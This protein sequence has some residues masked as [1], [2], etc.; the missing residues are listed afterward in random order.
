MTKSKGINKPRESQE[1][2]ALRDRII[3]RLRD[4]LLTASEV[5]SVWGIHRQ[6]VSRVMKRVYESLTIEQRFERS[7]MPEP[8]SGCWLWT[9]E[10]SGSWGYGR[11]HLSGIRVQAHRFSYEMNFGK[12]PE[13]LVVC[14]R[15]DV[16]VCVNPD[17]LFIVTQKDNMRDRQAKGKYA[18]AEKHHAAKLT[19]ERAREIKDALSGGE[20]KKSLAR[21]HGVSP[22]TIHNISTGLIWKSA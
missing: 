15:C 11:F 9:E 4:T 2:C 5:A 6:Q 16:P 8:N 12:I 10:I 19:T 3:Y 7:Y 1:H 20:S 22:K 17:H 18:T 13:G 14:H 21:K